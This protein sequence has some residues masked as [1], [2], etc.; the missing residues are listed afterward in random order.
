MNTYNVKFEDLVLIAEFMGF[1]P[2]EN[3]SLQGVFTHHNKMGVYGLHGL[4]FEYS[5]SWNSLMP[6]VRQIQLLHIDD[7]KYKKPVMN[8]LLEVDIMVL[9]D[10]VV[11]FL[12]W[13]KSQ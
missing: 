13:Y 6:V 12:K 1:S 3:T 7:F 8:A 4:R 10:A 11:L 5:T 2:K 9:F